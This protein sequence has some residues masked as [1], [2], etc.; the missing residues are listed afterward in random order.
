MRSK[1]LTGVIHLPD[2]RLNFNL[3]FGGETGEKETPGE[4]S[5]LLGRIFEQAVALSPELQELM[6]D[7]AEF[8]KGV[9]EKAKQDPVN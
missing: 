2:V 9:T 8:I 6:V 7:F 4:E 1:T 5:K 3:Y